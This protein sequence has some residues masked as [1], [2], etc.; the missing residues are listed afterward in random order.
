VSV[1]LALVRRRLGDHEFEGNLVYLARPCLKK[2][3]PSKSP[4][5]QQNFHLQIHTEGSVKMSCFGRRMI[6]DGNLESCWTVENAWKGQTNEN[7]NHLNY[8]KH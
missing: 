8:I 2:P 7:L 1:I 6:P 5:T 3:N 4:V